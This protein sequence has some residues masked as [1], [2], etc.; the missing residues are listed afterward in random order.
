MAC[1]ALWI[2][3]SCTAFCIAGEGGTASTSACW[4]GIDDCGRSWNE[5]FRGL[6]NGEGGGGAPG[7]I[8]GF[9]TGATG[10]SEVKRGDGVCERT[11]SLLSTA[12]LYLET[13][14]NW[15]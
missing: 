4:C 14:R 15:S 8:A 1:L 6:W 11:E 13:L 2:L 5:G 3:P 10:G 7:T 9:T 12:F